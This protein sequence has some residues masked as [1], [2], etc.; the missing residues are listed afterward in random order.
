MAPE[1]EGGLKGAVAVAAQSLREQLL[2]LAGVA[3]AEVDGDD[4]A[5]LGV[6]IRLAPE[7][8]AE[9]VGAEVQRVLTQHGVHS[10]LGAGEE[11]PPPPPLFDSEPERA[12]AAAPSA[13]PALV[14][15][16]VVVEEA[17]DSL[18]ITVVASDGRRVA[19][20]A[21]ISE[22]GL[23]AAV[24][25]AA[26]MLIVGAE[27]RVLSLEWAIVGGSRAVT[28]VLEAPGGRRGAGAA[29][30]RASRAYAVARAAWSAL[31]D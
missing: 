12:A 28:V 11:A 17:R 29:L 20:S 2:A 9:A 5:P 18:Q 21:E 16:S 24:I 10:R 30:V 4:A 25:T 23:A 6:R 7:V 1:A 15:G 26:G 13:P 27:P 3:E 19:R 22:E 14:L 8:E 31:T